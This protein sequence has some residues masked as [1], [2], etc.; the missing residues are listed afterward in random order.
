MQGVWGE[1]GVLFVA[2]LVVTAVGGLR[3]FFIASN[4][5][6]TLCR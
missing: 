5:D 6:T 3:S 4:V 1:L 2:Q